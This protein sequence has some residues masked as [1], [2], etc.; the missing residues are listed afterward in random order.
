MKNSHTAWVVFKRVITLLFILYI[1]LYF[2]VETGI[3]TSLKEKT[4]ITQENI[5]KFEEDVKNGEYVD[6]K[7]YIET[8][9]VDTSNIMSDAGYLI[10]N[11]ASK[12]VGEHLV[13]FFEFV[14]KLIK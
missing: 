9:D 10:S 12:I 4:I 6:I 8:N 3:N 2:Q 5:E 11:Q 13:D 7:N 14:G 1:V